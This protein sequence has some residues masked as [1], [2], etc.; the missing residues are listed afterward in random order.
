M[1]QCSGKYNKENIFLKSTKLNTK[2]LLLLI[3]R[4]PAKPF[5]DSCSHA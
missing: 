4:T 1:A 3:P 2:A 5:P